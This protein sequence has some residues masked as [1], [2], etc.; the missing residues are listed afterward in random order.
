MPTAATAFV[1]RDALCSL[2]EIVSWGS[3]AAAAPSLAW[4]RSLRAALAPHV[5]GQAYVN[6]IDP[7]LSGWESAYYGSNYAR[8][9]TVKRRYD[10]T[11]VFRFPQGIRL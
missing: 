6:Y 2:Q 9:R 3:P 1:H 4:L 10:P 5:S 8:L 11:G 7:G